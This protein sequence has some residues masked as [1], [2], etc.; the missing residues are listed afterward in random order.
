MDFFTKKTLDVSPERMEALRS[1][2][3]LI[4]VRIIRLRAQVEATRA[5]AI[6]ENVPITLVMADRDLTNHLRQPGG[7]AGRSRSWSNT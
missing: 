2:A 3:R 4:G 7:A 6:A 1:V 5:M